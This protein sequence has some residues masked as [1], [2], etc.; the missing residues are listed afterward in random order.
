MDSDLMNQVNR[1]EDKVAENASNKRKWEGN[2]GGSSSQQQNKGHKVIRA[3]IVGPSDKKGYAG[4]L[5]LA[6]ASLTTQRPLVAKQKTKAIYYECRI[7]GHYKSNYPK[8]EESEPDEQ[9]R[10]R[11]SP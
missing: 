5:P 10:E 6:S 7:L 9:A 3:H 4:N 2:H 11:K 8:M 1:Q